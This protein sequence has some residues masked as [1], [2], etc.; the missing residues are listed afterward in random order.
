MCCQPQPHQVALA[1]ARHLFHPSRDLLN[2]LPLALRKFPCV[3]EYGSAMA[4]FLSR[5][6]WSQF[7]WRQVATSAFVSYALSAPREMRLVPRSER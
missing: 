1:E 4:V 5:E 2:Q 6:M 7:M 3:P